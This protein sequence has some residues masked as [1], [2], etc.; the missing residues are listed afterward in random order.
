MIAE[1]ILRL[2]RRRARTH[3]DD[4]I[5][6]GRLL[7]ANSEIRKGKPNHLSRST[8]IEIMRF[9]GWHT[10]FIPQPLALRRYCLMFWRQRFVT[11]TGLAPL[12]IHVFWRQR[13]SCV[14]LAWHCGTSGGIN[15]KA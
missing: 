11:V 14:R 6:H 15:N 10:T 2:R 8:A 5:G 12:P 7:K 3:D 9:M 1:C 13:V 4:A